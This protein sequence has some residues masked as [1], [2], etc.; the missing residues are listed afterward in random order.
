MCGICGI[1]GTREGFAVDE[2]LVTGMRERIYH[3]GP[4][5]GGSWHSAEQRVALGHRRLSIIDL[6]AAGHQPMSN[7][8][9]TVWVTFG[10]EIYNHAELRPELEAEGHVYRSQTDTETILH[11]YEEEGPRCVERL[12]GMF[13]YAIWDSRTRELHLARDRL[14]KKPL[15]YAEPYGG[16]L[17]ASEI[18]A[19]LAHPSL[20]AELDENA[21]FHYLTFVCAPAPMTMFKGIRKLA[22]AE[23]MTVR[24]DGST[25]FDTYWSPLSEE[26]AREVAS[27][28]EDELADRLLALL[29]ESIRRRM[30]SDVPFGVFL[31]GGIDSSTNVALM[32]ELMD[33]PVRTFSVGFPDYPRH[34]ELSHARAVARH[35]HTDHHEIV[36]DSGDLEA[37]IPEL[38]YH[39]DEPLADWVAVPLHY[40]ANLARESGTIVVQIGEGS[41]E[42]FHGYPSYWSHA[43]FRSRYWPPFQRVPRPLRR[44]LG[45]A[46]TGVAFR[47][48][49][50]VAHAQAIEDAAEGRLPFWG[51][52][53]AYQGALKER[54]LSNGH[55]H[56]DSYA[57]VER[58]WREAER[59]LPDADLLQKM[60]YL[61]LKNRLAELLL[62]RVDKMTMASSVEARVPFLDHELVRFAIAL[63]PEMKVRGRSGKYLLKRAVRGL[64]PPEIVNRPK[65]GF[66]A[67]VSEWFRGGL[68]ERARNQIRA[69]SLAERGLLDYDAIDRL[70]RSHRAGRGDWAFQLWNVYNVSAWHDYWVAGR[71]PAA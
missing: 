40:L 4:D 36:I 39:Q 32:S 43:R 3:R 56:P 63:P 8:D 42:L 55:P 15:Y 45:R 6:S 53:I 25:T 71:T 68:G 17:F 67:P 9:G 7:E 10:G 13:H 44:A 46:A 1:L 5:D 11:L 27:Q 2:E 38:V 49:R 24:A 41:D 61:E 33:E 47:L 58:L 26:D 66:S 28:S 29:R 48:G 35:F 69:S 57:I 52:A 14:G 54:V 21:F 30:M 23:R 65:Q 59:E 16:F 37:F 64:L 34:D 22:P 12:H 62:M 31:S 20:T 70:W 19:L 18:K 50:G 51:G 60:T